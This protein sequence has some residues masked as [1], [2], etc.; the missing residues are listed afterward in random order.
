M[1]AF[2]T[3]VMERLPAAHDD[4][5][6]DVQLDYYGKQLASAGSD[7]RIKIFDVVDG[8]Q[9]QQTAELVG[10]DG[11]V[12][13]RMAAAD[14][15]EP[16]RLTPSVSQLK[17]LKSTAP[18]TTAVAEAVRRRRSGRIRSSR[19]RG[20]TGARAGRTLYAATHT[21]GGASGGRPAG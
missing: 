3:T 17:T 14:Q 8:Q 19:G 5:V 20:T 9:R 12:W 13:M 6:H 1:G 16:A 7:R 18:R 4:L 2:K 21:F 10:H 11:P 15:N